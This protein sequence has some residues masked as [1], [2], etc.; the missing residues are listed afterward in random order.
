MLKSESIEFIL[1]PLIQEL[2]NDNTEGIGLGGSFARGTATEFS[3]VDIAHFGIYFQNT[4][5]KP[6]CSVAIV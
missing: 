1:T 6:L 3:D 5:E 2:A 4:T